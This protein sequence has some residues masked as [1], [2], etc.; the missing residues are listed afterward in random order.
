MIRWI[1]ERLGTAAFDTLRPD[2]GF[3]LDVRDLVDKAGNAP[4]WVRERVEAGRDALRDGRTVIVACDFGISRSNAIAAGILSLEEHRPYDDALLEVA[5]VT[6]EAEI[7]VDFAQ[8]VKF[9]LEGQ[10]SVRRSATLVTGASG[11]IGR[12]LL[13]RLAADGRAVLAPV[14]AELDLSAGGVRLNAYCS[15]HGVGQIVHLAYPRVYTNPTAVGEAIANLRAVLETC[16]LNRIRLVYVSCAVVFGGYAASELWADETLPM[17]PAGLHG[18]AKY[19]EEKLIE[20][21]MA[22]SAVEVAICRLSPVY[23]PSGLRPRL[24]QNFEAKIRAGDV[25][26]THRYRNARPALDLLHI[27]DAA[28]ALARIAA[29]TGSGIYH[30]G[31]GALTAT[32]D[33]AMMIGELLGREVN[34]QEVPIDENVANVLMDFRKAGAELGW[35]PTINLVEGLREMLP[36]SAR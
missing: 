10:S 36:V 15:R 21:Y 12:G 4:D 35:A 2:D 13:P 34:H 14:R 11:F 9:A 7:K 32:S 16:A 31:S 5:A 33:I 1:R 30:F 19:L 22:R 27:R 8:T 28:D 25:V 29:S 17:R 18:D 3:V 20:L 24:I 6:G 26:Q 23:G